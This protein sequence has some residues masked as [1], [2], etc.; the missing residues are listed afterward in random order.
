[1]KIKCELLRRTRNEAVGSRTD[2]GCFQSSMQKS[3]VRRLRFVVSQWMKRRSVD[4]RT[5]TRF[6]APK[7]SKHDSP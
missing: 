1:M 6:D 5:W 2:D 4:S 7:R 3:T